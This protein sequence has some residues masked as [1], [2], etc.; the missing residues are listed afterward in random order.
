MSG[1]FDRIMLAQRVCRSRTSRRLNDGEFRA[2]IAAL[3]LAGQSPVRGYL[4]VSEAVPV[5]TEDIAD[6][7]GVEEAVAA[8]AVGKLLDLE[9]LGRDVERD[10][11]RFLNW[12]EYNPAPRPSDS[13]EATRE[14]KRR[15]REREREQ[16]RVREA[17]AKLP[18]TEQPQLGQHGSGLRRVE[19]A[20]A[21][22]PA[23]EFDRVVGAPK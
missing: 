14:R 19:A 13:R 1:R 16:K 21:P 9:T 17:A 6:E 10:C 5:T 4:L 12:D 7:A 18:P 8:S 3:C 15:Q 11:L 22:V 2:Y 23:E 20:P